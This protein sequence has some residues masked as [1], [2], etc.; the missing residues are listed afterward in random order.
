MRC[1]IKA[2]DLQSY[3]EI[4]TIIMRQRPIYVESKKR[5]TLST[6]DLSLELLEAIK[7]KGAIVTK[8]EQYDL[9]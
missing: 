5:L 8:D 7:A 6:N 4:K 9:D 2:L 3:D 1:K